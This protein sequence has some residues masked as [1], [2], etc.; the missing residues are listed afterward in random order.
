MTFNIPQLSLLFQ[1][2]TVHLIMHKEEHFMETQRTFSE[3]L[4]DRVNMVF[5][6]FV[7]NVFDNQKLRGR[8][9]VKH[10]FSKEK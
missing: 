9:F 7:R 10:T 1:D 6:P 2:I 8:I 4:K 3:V 5:A